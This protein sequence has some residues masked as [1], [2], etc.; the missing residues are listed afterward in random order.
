MCLSWLFVSWSWSYGTWIYNYLRKS[1]S[2]SVRTPLRRC[3][4]DKIS[5]DKICQW[6]PTGPCFSPGTPV[7]PTNTTDPHDVVE[8]FLKVFLSTIY[9]NRLNNLRNS[10]F[11]IYF[12][13]QFY[14]ISYHNIWLYNILHILLQKRRKHAAGIS[15]I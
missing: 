5:C 6:L 1:V 11:S 2:S 8:I 12:I 3:V 14:I 13:S 10:L 15:N 7:F 9:I 4:F